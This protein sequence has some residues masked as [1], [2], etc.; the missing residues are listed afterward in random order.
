MHQVSTGQQEFSVLTGIVRPDRWPELSAE[1]VKK[2]LTHAKE[3]FD[4]VVVDV[5]FNLETDE[6]ITSDLFAPRRNAATLGALKE[7]ECILEVA[8][9]DA[10]GIA[11]FIRAHYVLVESFPDSM[12]MIV[13]NKVKAGLDAQGSSHASSTLSR[14]AGLHEVYELPYDDRAINAAYSVGSPL[15][16]ASKNSKL[17]KK[18]AEIAQVLSPQQ[19]VTEL[20]KSRFSR[21]R[22]QEFDQVQSERHRDSA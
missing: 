19:P 1:R 11:R 17:R 6:E 7:A 22:K 14:F 21:S 8:S 3:S 15:S 10:V 9:A 13:V 18:F 2:V 5:G 12:R 20:K 16:S 4:V